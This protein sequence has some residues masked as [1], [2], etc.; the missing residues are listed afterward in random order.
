VGLT[1]LFDRN[2]LV[3]R[4]LYSSHNLAMQSSA[5]NVTAGT[6][7]SEIALAR[8]RKNLTT[9][10]EA[11]AI[12]GEPALETLSLDGHLILSWQYVEAEF[13]GG[14]SSRLK[15]ARLVHI[16]FDAADKVIA[17]KIVNHR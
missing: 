2:D 14:G 17:V 15:N 13:T 8:I 9:R 11:I 10:A 1:V 5:S 7:A 12:L 4:A 3:I 6:P 16:A